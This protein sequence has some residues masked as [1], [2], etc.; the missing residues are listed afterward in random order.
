MSADEGLYDDPGFK[1]A[2][3]LAQLGIALVTVGLIVTVA[4]EVT[5]VSL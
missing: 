1:A 5:G 3:W 4:L 2:L